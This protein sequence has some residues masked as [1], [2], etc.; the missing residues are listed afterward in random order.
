MN[1]RPV[2]YSKPGGSWLQN[3]K[4]EGRDRGAGEVGRGGG[5]LSKKISSKKYT[6]TPVL[7]I[8][9]VSP[10]ILST[11]QQLTWRNAQE[12]P[13]FFFVD[14]YLKNVYTKIK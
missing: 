2:A 5:S 6:I 9:G 10:G 8:M 12:L 14:V 11:R 7:L 3:K 13:I 1:I 4:E